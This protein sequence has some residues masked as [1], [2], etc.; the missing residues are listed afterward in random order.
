MV[1]LETVVELFRASEKPYYDGF[2]FTATV[3]LNSQIK[4]IITKLLNAPNLGFFEIIEIDG[5]SYEGTDLTVHN[6]TSIF[7][8]YVTK[9]D[10]ADTFYNDMFEFLSSST[11]KKGV[12]PSDY[13]IVKDD[14]YCT[15]ATPPSYIKQTLVL[16]DFINSLSKI[17]H[18]HDT[19]ND[20]IRYKLVFVK[21]SDSKSSSISLETNCNK[22]II[23][24]SINTTTLS[25]LSN[26]EN[27]FKP[28]FNENI[29]I[30][31]NSLVDYV[32]EQSL[33]FEGLIGCWDDFLDVYNKNLAVYMSGFSFHKARKDVA[34]A[35]TE[36]AE[37]TSKI[38]SEL[39]VKVL[40]IP[41]T[42]AA[43]I[44][45]VKLD[46]KFDLIIAFFG[47]AIASTIVFMVIKNQENQ[48]NRIS[49]AK[50]LVFAPF[51]KDKETYPLVL[52]EEISEV[53][54]NLNKD[55]K[56][57]SLTIATF[58][59]MTIIPVIIAITSLLLKFYN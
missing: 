48:F 26:K 56:T 30:F 8:C 25:Y 57:A 21:N 46:G 54:E 49:H 45:L 5:H 37:K 6:G 9:K 35:E 31:R 33:D 19:R 44:G 10:S 40:S 14:F 59:G 55:E 43:S 18:Y 58:K 3:S 29:G 17:A 41:V 20:A 4:T 47:I 42:L 15:D 7:Y 12:P 13:Y 50:N 2:N 52:Q 11:L 34:S 24:F 27:K 28:H 16:C 23:E 39:T 32:S 1:N 22:E 38:I 53:L 36:F 51:Q